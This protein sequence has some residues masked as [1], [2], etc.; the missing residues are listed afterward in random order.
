MQRELT[1][2][3]DIK[4][5]VNTFYSRVRTNEVLGNIFNNAI[6]NK[7]NG[8]LN[9]MYRF[10]QTILFHDQSYHGSPL[11]PHMKLVIGEV[12]FEKWITIFTQTVDGHFKGEIAEQAKERGQKIA[13][14]FQ[15][16]L[17]YSF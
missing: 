14:T 9:K 12:H 3:D 16:K 1:N 11:P 10:W 4:F 6:G 8:H 13:Q 17:E 15:L 2:I 7:W 5:L